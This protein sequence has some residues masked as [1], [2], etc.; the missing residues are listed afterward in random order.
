MRKVDRWFPWYSIRTT[1]QRNNATSHMRSSDLPIRRHALLKENSAIT[2]RTIC[3]IWIDTRALHRD[4]HC[5]QLSLL[6]GGQK[7][8]EVAI[9]SIGQP[10]PFFSRRAVDRYQTAIS[11]MIYMTHITNSIPFPPRLNPSIVCSGISY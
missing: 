3:Q 7:D 6:V 10:N 2:A 1:T 4:L 5:G 11:T 8:L 9:L